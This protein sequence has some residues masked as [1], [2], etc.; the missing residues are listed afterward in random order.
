MAENQ[1]QQFRFSEA[2]IWEL[3]RNYYEEEGMKAWNNDQVPQYI[4]SN[5]MMATS[6]AEMIFGFLQ[7][8]AG[9]GDLSEPVTIM[10]LGAGAGRLAFHTLHRLCELR[11][12]AGIEL[13][14]FRYVMTD[15]ASKNVLAW[16]QHPALQPF[17]REGL[18]DFARFDA[19][20]DTEVHLAVAQ[21][22][23]RPGDLKQPLLIVANYFFDVIPQELIYVHDGKV[24]ECDI[25]V[26][27]PDNLKELTTSEKLKQMKLNYVNRPAPEYTEKTYPYHD[28]IDMYVTELDDSYI[29]FP[30]AGLTCLDRLHRLSQAGFLLIT[31]DKGDHRL[32]HWDL[33]D[34]PEFFHHGS[35]SLTANYHAIQ[36]VL[37]Q[38]GGLSL[39][40]KEHHY[41]A[42]NVG[43]IL[44]LESPMRYANTRLAFRRFVDRFGPDEF[45]SLKE[46]VD[47]HSGTM[48]LQQILAFWRLG[49]YD[50]EFFIQST[51]RISALLPEAGEEELMDIQNGIHIMWSS[52]YVMEQRYDLAL[53]AGLLLFEMEFYDDAKEFLSLSIETDEDESV[54]TV[55]FCLA[56]CS[57]EQGDKEAA[58]VYLRD[59]LVLE[60]EHEDALALLHALTAEE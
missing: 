28:L 27:F 2:P 9:M 15:L 16:Q 58:M 56:I 42:I 4:S 23:I 12:Y 3:Q 57:Y 1:R 36:H 18:L 48:G 13:P 60:P 37:E 44:M 39:F 35:F 21:T 43:C 49:G 46:W 55:L 34:P 26:E 51:K 17:I 32:E 53:D 8:R 31:A 11:D 41:H 45:F 7:D 33:A 40:T 47:Q 24:Y 30:V 19:V 5:P 10:E 22:T 25:S 6:Y 20:Q 52:F 54:P 59:A 38:R 50:A 29:L 14:P